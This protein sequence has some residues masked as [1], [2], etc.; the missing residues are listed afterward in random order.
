MVQIQIKQEENLRTLDFFGMFA[1]GWP[2]EAEGKDVVS[3]NIISGASPTGLQSAV[4]SR[5][6]CLTPSLEIKVTHYKSPTCSQ[7]EVPSAP[8][9][10]S[11]SLSLLSRLRISYEESS[12]HGNGSSETPVTQSIPHH[13]LRQSASDVR[14]YVN[15][16][17]LAEQRNERLDQVE[18]TS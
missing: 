13:T 1:N 4:I 14:M 15:G 6:S 5:V 16:S 9:M 10:Y 8:C 2:L 12:R 17:F 3:K 18:I 11:H 7:Y